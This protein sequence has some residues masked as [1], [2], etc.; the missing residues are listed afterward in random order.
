M[1]AIAT[2]IFGG[3]YPNQLYIISQPNKKVIKTSCKKF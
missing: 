1:R 3:F 2:K